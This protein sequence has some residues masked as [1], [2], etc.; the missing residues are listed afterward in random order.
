LSPCSPSCECSSSISTSKTMKT[1][2]TS[3]RG[4]SWKWDCFY[5][6]NAHKAG[7]VYPLVLF[8]HRYQW[9]H[10][11]MKE[12]SMPKTEIYQSFLICSCRCWNA[13]NLGLA[14]P[15]GL[16]IHSHKWERDRNFQ[17]ESMPKLEIHQSFLIFVA[18]ITSNLLCMFTLF[19]VTS[20]HVP[21]QHTLLYKWYAKLYMYH[22]F[23]VSSPQSHP[24]RW[25]KLLS[26]VGS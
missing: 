16:F 2:P 17:D 7:L 4:M 6:W 10:D 20:I 25:Q 21:I 8:S 3:T 11:W 26:T 23:T 9:E 5:W 13:L 12:G 22:V 1:L 18:T 24:V 14:Y 19:W 15:L